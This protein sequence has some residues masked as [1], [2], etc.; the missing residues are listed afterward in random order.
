MGRARRLPAAALIAAGCT[1]TLVATFV[2]L[3]AVRGEPPD[4]VHR[5]ILPQ[6]AGGW[7]PFFEHTVLGAAQWK[8]IATF[9]LAATPAGAFLTIG[10]L[11]ALKN[12]LAGD[13]AAPQPVRI[14][15]PHAQRDG[16][17]P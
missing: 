7:L 15:D 10:L 9:L 11:L 5:M 6:A 4:A 13:G 3:P 2:I 8:Y 14:I 17:S 12:R 16:S 1:W